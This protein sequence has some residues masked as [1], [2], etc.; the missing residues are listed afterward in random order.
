MKAQKIILAC[1]ALSFSSCATYQYAKNIKSISFDDDVH[2][3]K[4]VGPV[5]G[6]D[7]IW[8]IFGY[9]LGGSPTLDRAFASARNQTSSG[10]NTVFGGATESV[11]SDKALRYINHVTT[12]TDGFDALVV[13]KKCLIVT[14][15]GYR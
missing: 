10:I 13:G 3:G 15:T 14:G 6:E 2:Q 4:S 1:V 8:E 9:K 12:S 5:R 11:G 7:C